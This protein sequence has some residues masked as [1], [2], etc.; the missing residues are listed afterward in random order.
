VKLGVFAKSY[1]RPSVDEALASAAGDGFSCVQFNLACSG[2]GTL[3]RE[4]V[5]ER[6]SDEIERAARRHN[7]EIVAA[8]AC[9]LTREQTRDTAIV[10]R[11]RKTA[12]AISTTARNGPAR[13]CHTNGSQCEPRCAAKEM[14]ISVIGAL[15]SL[16]E[17][18]LIN[19]ESRMRVRG[20]G[21]VAARKPKA[22]R[23]PKSRRGLQLPA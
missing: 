15:F 11:N 13:Y 10:E 23:W 4:P 18:P 8:R 5:P 19:L 3:P 17:I 9:A 6:V 16:C 14:R 20:P 12:T 21:T 1:E 2:L 7:I 22:P